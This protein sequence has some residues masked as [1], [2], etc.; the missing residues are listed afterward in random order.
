MLPS[1]DYA[2][3]TRRQ[4]KQSTKHNKRPEAYITNEQYEEPLKQRKARIV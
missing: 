2:T 1:F 3:S 4:K